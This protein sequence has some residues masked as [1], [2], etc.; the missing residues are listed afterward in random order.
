[1]FHVEPNFVR[2]WQGYGRALR[3]R[4]AALKCGADPS[5][6]DGELVR[7]GEVLT[8]ARAQMIEALQPYWTTALQDLDAVPASL[9]YF[10][11]W[12]SEQALATAL[13][14]H[15]LRD[16][17]RG[18]TSYGPHRFDVLLRLEGRPAWCGRWGV[19]L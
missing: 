19:G 6:W 17:E 11:G 15:I 5:L 14:A 12:R 13:T 2:H 3:Q 1:M 16:R 9:G 18:S 4:N 8:S 7:L 10:Q